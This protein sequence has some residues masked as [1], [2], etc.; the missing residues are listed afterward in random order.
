M[1]NRLS[2]RFGPGCPASG[3]F[4]VDEVSCFSFFSAV[5][6]PLIII[7]VF[8]KLPSPSFPVIFKYISASSVAMR[9]VPSRE[10][11]L[12]YEVSS[13]TFDIEMIAILAIDL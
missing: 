5:F 8:F 2:D 1:K 13:E 10:P 3:F 4:F 6:M 7:S 9:T 11:E 12:F